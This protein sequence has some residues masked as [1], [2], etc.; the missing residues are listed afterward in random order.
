MAS[1]I[2]SS[3]IL[4]AKCEAAMKQAESASRTAQVHNHH[5]I[6]IS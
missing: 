6:L 3:A 4:E 2:C 1:L 5:Q